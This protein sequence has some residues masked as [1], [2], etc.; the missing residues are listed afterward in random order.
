MRAGVFSLQNSGDLHPRRLVMEWSGH[1]GIKNGNPAPQDLLPQATSTLLVLLEGASTFTAARWQ[2][3]DWPLR[4]TAQ[5]SLLQLQ[6]TKTQAGRE[7]IRHGV[8]FRGPTPPSC[9]S[10]QSMQPLCSEGHPK[11]SCVCRCLQVK[12]ENTKELPALWPCLPW[13]T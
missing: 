13:T 12:Q 11:K 4:A 8:A 2:W 1:P 7:E 5:P 10:P 3:G 6:V 9:S